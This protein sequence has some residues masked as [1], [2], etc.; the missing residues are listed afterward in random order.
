VPGARSP[1]RCP[2]GWS[3]AAVWLGRHGSHGYEC[4]L[5]PSQPDGRHWVVMSP[6]W[7]SCATRLPA[8]TS[9]P[10]PHLL[11]G[12]PP[13]CL[14]APPPGERRVTRIQLLPPPMDALVQ[15]LTG[16]RALL[17]LPASQP[18]S[19][20][21]PRRHT[22]LEYLGCRGRRRLRPQGPGPPRVQETRDGL[23]LPAGPL[24]PACRSQ[25]PSHEVRL[26][27]PLSQDHDELWQNPSDDRRLVVPVGRM[28]LS[29]AA[30]KIRWDWDIGSPQQPDLARIEAPAT[31]GL[32]HSGRH[33]AE[34]FRDPGHRSGEDIG[35]WKS[36]KASRQTPAGRPNRREQRYQAI[37][38][39]GRTGRT[40]S[41]TAPET[42]G[43]ACRRVVAG[44]QSREL[45]VADSE[46]TDQL[47]GAQVPRI[48]GDLVRSIAVNSAMVAARSGHAWSP[49]GC[50]DS[51]FR[52]IC[53]RWVNS[54][55][56]APASGLQANT[57]RKRPTTSAGAGMVGSSH[58]VVAVQPPARVVVGGGRARGGGEA[59]QVPGPLCRKL[60]TRARA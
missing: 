47:H 1:I 20:R 41:E 26:V 45:I 2:C 36:H 52:S 58:N 27:L 30:G 56:R 57:S 38:R 42:R 35:I 39:H 33:A 10:E 23:G 46:F 59:V 50:S 19:D 44:P 31:A 37:P 4:V 5:P 12:D 16:N 17:H 40:L 9:Q 15:V 49:F 6:R 13:L 3:A 55:S 24:R 8:L 7:S 48:G 28:F 25:S 32:V 54:P 14:R 60:G 43:R 34:D 11:P 29:Y 22:A 51:R 53:G 21:G 18:R